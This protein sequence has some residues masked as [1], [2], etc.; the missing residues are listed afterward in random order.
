V[1]AEVRQRLS[2]S[3]QAVPKFEMKRFH[4]IKSSVVEVRL[5][6]Q[7]ENFDGGGGGGGRAWGNV[8]T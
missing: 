5:K 1:V 7:I 6:S 4:L 3:T 8:R 2:V